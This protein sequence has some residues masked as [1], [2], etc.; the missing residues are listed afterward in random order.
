MCCVSTHYEHGKLMSF[1]CTTA[2]CPL[3]TWGQAFFNYLPSL[4]GNSLYAAIF[5]IC[6]VLQIAFGIKKKTW[7]FMS[8]MVVG[9][10]LEV[11]GYAGRIK[12]HSDPF[13]KNSFLMLD[14]PLSPKF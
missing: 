14:F 3:T 8:G 13:T 12:M 11:I 10:L 7:G 4:P 2:I 6:L 5:G 9:L 1:K